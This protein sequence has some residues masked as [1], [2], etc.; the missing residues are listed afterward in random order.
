MHVISHRALR[1]FWTKYPDSKNALSRWYKIVQG[2]QFKS[3][4]ELRSTFP[5]ADQVGSLVVFNIGGN[6][7]RLIASIHFN[8]SK[9]YIRHVL[10][11]S[12]YDKETWKL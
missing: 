12:D 3:F 11:H 8:R 6:K 2:G 1:L 7:Y 10:T 4:A 9:I 5:S